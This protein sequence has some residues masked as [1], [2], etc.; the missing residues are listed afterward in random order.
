[1]RRT[2]AHHYL[3]LLASSNNDAEAALHHAKAALQS[4]RTHRGPVRKL[5]ASLLASLGAAYSLHGQMAEADDQFAAANARQQEIGLGASAQAVTLLN[6]WA[7]INERAGDA[8][9]AQELAE[10]ALALAGAEGRSPFLLMNRARALECQGRIDEAEAGYC[11]AEKLAAERA[12]V[13]AL[14]AAH[15]GQASVELLRGN[16]DNARARLARADEAF[17]TLPA[18][19]PQRIARLWIEGRL[20]LAAGDPTAAQAAF[21]QAIEAAPQQASAV[22]PRLG[23]AEVALARSE[24]TAALDLASA[25]RTQAAHLQGGKPQSFRTAIAAVM[26]AR[27]LEAAG[28]ID[29]A[30]REAGDALEQLA[31]TVDVAHPD[32]ATATR[33]ARAESAEP[34]CP[35]ASTLH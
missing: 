16:L 5:E 26:C 30:R 27:A 19:H 18:T 4:V 6:N 25:A 29:K 35:S 23:L 7:V 15:L 11:E 8:R 9:R 3:A 20:A 28:Q 21:E 17:A 31:A 24:W 34:H 12:T 33:L 2:E 22:T 14:V 1:L 10:R 13:P 32:V